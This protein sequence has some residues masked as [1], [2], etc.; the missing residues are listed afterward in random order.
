MHPY[1]PQTPLNLTAVLIPDKILHKK[2]TRSPSSPSIF[3]RF[4]TLIPIQ[5]QESQVDPRLIYRLKTI[6]TDL[7]WSI[8][9]S[10]CLISPYTVPK[11]FEPSTRTI[12]FERKS[13]TDFVDPRRDSLKNA[14]LSHIYHRLK[15]LLPNIRLTNNLTQCQ[16][17]LFEQTNFQ[18]NCSL[19]LEYLLHQLK[20]IDDTN[21]LQMIK[22]NE[23]FQLST[24]VLQLISS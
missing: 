17:L 16:Q 21:F 7:R 3:T 14:I 11:T 20:Q 5:A 2:Q 8:P 22:T 10:Q 15:I 13:S 12:L 9:C 4:D 24:D 1:S 18:T 19:H 23:E 6:T